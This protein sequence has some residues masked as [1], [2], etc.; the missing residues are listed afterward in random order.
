[1]L[2]LELHSFPYLPM[3]KVVSLKS[4]A[5]LEYF[6]STNVHMELTG[7]VLTM[8]FSVTIR[9]IQGREEHLVH[10]LVIYRSYEPHYTTTP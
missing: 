2:K 10:F 9:H 3:I 8:T 4:Y 7:Y 6:T 5:C 1:M